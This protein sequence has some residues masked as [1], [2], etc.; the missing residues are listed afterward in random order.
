MG[1]QGSK[2]SGNSIRIIRSI[3]LN[4][5]IEFVRGRILVF[6][7]LLI[8]VLVWLAKQLSCWPFHV[9]LLPK[10]INIIVRIHTNTN[11]VLRASISTSA[12]KGLSIV[13]TIAVSYWYWC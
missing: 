4:F 10:F 7:L 3:D 11:I 6:M 2:N 9:L 8:F 1:R 5:R 12:C 13:L